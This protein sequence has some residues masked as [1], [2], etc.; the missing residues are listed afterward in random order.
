MSLDWTEGWDNS[1]VKKIF[2]GKT[3]KI[4]IPFFYHI[5]F[6]HNWK[7]V[8]K[9]WAMGK[10]YARLYVVIKKAKIFC[11][12]L[13]FFVAICKAESIHCLFKK[14]V[15][16]FFKKFLLDSL[17]PIV[18][19]WSKPAKNLPSFIW[20]YVHTIGRP[21]ILT[22]NVAPFDTKFFYVWVMGLQ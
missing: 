5:V 7:C 3:Y 8:E 12:M 1:Q 4:Y 15:F 10:K 2:R 6:F 13:H 9:K 20:N 21:K 11:C 22:Y 14:L 17:V 18:Y 16:S 19:R